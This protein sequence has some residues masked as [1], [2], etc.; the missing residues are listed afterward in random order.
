MQEINYFS[1]ICAIILDNLLDLTGA[2]S[3]GRETESLN[4]R[5][6][7]KISFNLNCAYYFLWLNIDVIPTGHSNQY[8]QLLE[9]SGCANNKCPG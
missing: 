3:T 9:V 1:L 4:Q 6:F 5:I 7:A 8:H 2:P